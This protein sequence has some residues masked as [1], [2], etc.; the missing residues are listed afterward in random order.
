MISTRLSAA[1]GLLPE[2]SVQRIA[3]LL[4]ALEL[5][6]APFRGLDLSLR[7]GVPGGPDREA[8]LAATRADKKARGGRV[9]WVLLAGV[10]QVVDGW[11]R[12][13]ADAEVT[14]AIEFFTPG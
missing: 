11:T 9:E 4:A 2:A 5:P 8:F 12:P 13:V 14:A 10:G 1:C 6:S 3:S 7:P